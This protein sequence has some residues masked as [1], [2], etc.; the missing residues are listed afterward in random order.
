MSSSDNAFRSSWWYYRVFHGMTMWW[1]KMTYQL[2]HICNRSIPSFGTH[3]GFIHKACQS[4]NPISVMEKDWKHG[5]RLALDQHRRVAGGSDSQRQSRGTRNWQSALRLNIE[6]TDS[7]Y[8]HG[9]ISAGMASA[10]LEDT[11]V[12]TICFPATQAD[13]QILTRWRYDIRC[14]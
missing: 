14:W 11:L 9:Y 4:S 6:T 7:V 8:W 2:W 10:D 13:L 5:L 1:R 3:Y 12:S